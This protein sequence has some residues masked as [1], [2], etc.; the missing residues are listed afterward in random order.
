MTPFRHKKG[1][2]MD[3]TRWVHMHPT[4]SPGSLKPICWSGF[5]LSQWLT[6]SNTSTGLTI[7]PS[8]EL[9]SRTGRSKPIQHWYRFTFIKI[10][11]AIN[12]PN[13]NHDCA[14]TILPKRQVDKISWTSI[15]THQPYQMNGCTVGSGAHGGHGGFRREH[16]GGESSGAHGGHS[17]F[18]REH[19]SGKWNP[20]SSGRWN[21]VSSGKRNLDLR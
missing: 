18:R 4:G 14:N 19:L 10:M 12:N 13:I 15:H 8:S 5:W 11:F 3:R 16:H 21:P 9:T 7:W 17:G 2:K 6:R 1:E 20:V